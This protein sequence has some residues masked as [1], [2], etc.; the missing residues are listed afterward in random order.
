MLSGA[1]LPGASADSVTD[2]KKALDQRIS[3]LRD[4]LE[5][6]SREF[7][8]AAVTLERSQAELVDVRA[9]LATARTAL[10]KAQSHDAAVASQ[11]A[12]AEAEESKAVAG[13]RQRRE[14]EAELRAQLGMIARRTYVSLGDQGLNELSVALRSD[15]PDQFLERLSLAGAALQSQ[16]GA[17][18]RLAV[19]QADLRAR[20]EKLVAIRDQVAALKRRSEAAV[21][22]RELAESTAAEAERRQNQLVAEQ[23]AALAVIKARAAAEQASL[24]QMVAQQNQLSATL[25]A[26]ARAAAAAHH[27]TVGPPPP[28]SSGLIGYPVTAAIT[29]GFGLRLHPILHYYRMHTGVDFGAGCGTPVYAVA[30]GTMI[31]AG[32]AGGYGNRLVIDHGWVSGANLASSYSHL[33]YIAVRSGT[34]HRGQLV[35]RVGST[36]LSTGCHLHFET[37]VNG[38][39]VDPRK[40]L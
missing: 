9:R 18:Q 38:S 26:R 29:S 30:D 23:T 4:E 39:Y 16:A 19:Q 3:K 22:S 17:V 34:V 32:W 11:L 28:A 10:A 15:S 8:E 35:A 31:S 13:L 1:L 27:G 12:F 21:A 33:S 37:L 7:A 14:A 5:G 25:A 40:Y 2:R 20:A 24:K 36:G 6:T